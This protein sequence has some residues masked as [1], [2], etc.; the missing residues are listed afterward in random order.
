MSTAAGVVGCKRWRMRD[1]VTAEQVRRFVE[2]RIVPAYAVFGDNV[3]LGLQLHED[4]TLL[5]EQR[6]TSRA[7]RD[8][9]MS[10]SA[11]EAWWE[12][13]LPV[14]EQWGRLVEFVEEWDADILI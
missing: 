12:S 3:V 6:W 5:A 14:L 7:A 4:G 2:E 1:G 9:A 11:F 8:G 10:G 13:Y